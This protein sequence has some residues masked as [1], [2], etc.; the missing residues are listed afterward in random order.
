MD[1]KDKNK[2]KNAFKEANN[3]GISNND[4]LNMVQQQSGL[5]LNRQQKRLISRKLKSLK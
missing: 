3:L 1:Q 2:L 5:N 4:I